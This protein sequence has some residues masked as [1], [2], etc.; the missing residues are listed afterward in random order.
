MG[1]RGKTRG[2]GE[3]ILGIDLGTTNSAVAVVRDG[4]A[5]LLPSGEGARTT[6]SVVAVADE[7]RLVG[8]AAKNQA[9]KHCERTVQSVKRSMGEPGVTIDLGETSYT[10]EEVS[11]MI[12]GKLRRDAERRLGESVR[13]ATITV[14]AYFTDRQRQATKDAGEIAGLTV[15]RIVNEPTAAAMA[16]GVGEQLEPDGE[17]R[18]LVY[19]LGGGTFDVSILRVADGLFE[20][21]ATSGDTSLGGDDWDGALVN[22]AVERF[23][24]EHGIDLRADRQAM[25][26]LTEAAERAKCDLSA[27]TETELNVPF[28][29]SEGGEALDLRYHITRREFEELTAH[30]LDRT[31]GPTERAMEDAG[32][33]PETI[34]EVLLTGG[35]TRMMAVRRLVARLTGTDPRRDVNPEEA[36]ALGAAIQGGVIAGSLEDVLLV[37]VTPLSLGVE[38]RG[39]LFERIIPRNTT[40]PTRASKEFTTAAD[41]QTEV[42]IRVYQGERE[43]AAENELLDEFVLRDIPPAAAGVP[44]IEVTFVIDVDGIV[45]VSAREA[46]TGQSADVRIEGGVGLSETEIERM[47]TEAQRHERADR[48]RRRR[49]EA[50]NRLRDSVERARRVLENRA[51]IGPDTADGLERVVEEAESLLEQEEPPVDQLDRAHDRFEEILSELGLEVTETPGM[52]PDSGERP[53]REH[54]Q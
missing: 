30:L 23:E 26:R 34:D 11:A 24:H 7:Q 4:Q 49:T 17:Q 38:V 1:W 16:Y 20:V 41:G 22:W 35:A 46:T 42:E 45:Q 19:D 44:R 54:K 43:R 53:P 12:L 13:R 40:I 47:Q 3:S 6:P 21:V 31:V 10:P 8:Q 36:V 52:L 14:P 28:V 50:S 33:T 5:E 18:V 39:G 51:D 37:D 15:E 27:R 2:M 25:Q 48:E 29:A 32:V 9:V